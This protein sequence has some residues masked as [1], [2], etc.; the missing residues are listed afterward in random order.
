MKGKYIE[1]TDVDVDNL[2]VWKNIFLPELQRLYDNVVS[3]LDADNFDSFV[4]F[5]YSVS[6]HGHGHGQWC[7]KSRLIEALM[8][9]YD[10][11][12]LHTIITKV[13]KRVETVYDELQQAL[14]DNC[15]NLMDG[16][17]YDMFMLHYVPLILE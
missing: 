7:R 6:T 13:E 2:I 11:Y 5:A 16:L 12:E 4:R 9:D 17:R 3:K 15:S 14:N 10:S 1:V 8:D